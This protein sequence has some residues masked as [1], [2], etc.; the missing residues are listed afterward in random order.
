MAGRWL[1]DCHLGEQR[2]KGI[3]S[4]CPPEEDLRCTTNVVDDDSHIQ[5]IVLATEA[6]T[7][8]RV[9]YSWSQKCTK[10]NGSHRGDNPLLKPATGI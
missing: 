5:R 1:T 7:I 3:D 9:S 10:V 4:C 8:A 6:T 2:E